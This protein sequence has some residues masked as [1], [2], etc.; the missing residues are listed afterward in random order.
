MEPTSSQDRLRSA[1]VLVADDDADMRAWLRSALESAGHAV[2]EA[3]NGK[4]AMDLM[5]REVVDLV[6]TDLAMPEQEGIETIRQL[7]QEHPTLKIIAISGS[8]GK[9][10]LPVAKILGAAAVLQKPIQLDNLLQTVQRLLN[11]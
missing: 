6:I 5:K 11:E 10:F 1:R 8:L 3:A 7:R 2:L 9:T 4:R